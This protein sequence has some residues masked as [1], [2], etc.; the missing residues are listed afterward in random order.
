[1][2][3]GGRVTAQAANLRMLVMR[4][5]N[6]ITAEEVAELPTWAD[7]ERFDITAKAPSADP[8]APAL[9]SDTVAPMLRNLLADRFKMTYHTEQRLVAAYALVSAKPKL[10]KADPASRTFCKFPAPPPGTPAGS[11]VLTCQNATMA[12]FAARLLRLSAELTQPVLDATGISGGWDLTVIFNP[13]AGTANGPGPAGG[14]GA[15][16]PASDPSGSYT[17]FEAVE[18]QLGLK[19][20]KQKRPMEVFVIDHIEQKPTDN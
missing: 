6:V 4:A 18:K 14:L 11:R 7:T 12:Q 20:E 5:F 16:P 10:K 19:L 2:Q 9:D 13:N 1:M 17:I 3:A 15:A 8:S